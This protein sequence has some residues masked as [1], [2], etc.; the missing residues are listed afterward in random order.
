MTKIERNDFEICTK[1]FHNSNSKFILLLQKS[2][3]RNEYMDEWDEF[4]ETSLSEKEAF[5]SH[6]NMED[7]TDADYEHAK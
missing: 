4:N 1:I 5:N 2:V 7:I 6:L 3:Y